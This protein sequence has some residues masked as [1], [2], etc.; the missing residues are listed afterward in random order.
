MRAYRPERNICAGPRHWPKTSPDSP[1]RNL[2]FTGISGYPTGPT[3]IDPL[4]PGRTHPSTVWDF[5]HRAKRPWSTRMPLGISGA[6]LPIAGLPCARP[7]T[8]ATLSAT[9]PACHASLR[10][11]PRG[12]GYSVKAAH[13]R[14]RLRC[15]PESVPLCDRFRGRLA[16]KL[17][18]L[19]VTQSGPDAS[20]QSVGRVA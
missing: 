16:R 12:Q 6:V 10:K 14:G 5:R 15:N 18:C 2:R 1:L 8:R 13:R 7:G 11:A 3:A 9:A 17:E 19:H 4:R 20:A